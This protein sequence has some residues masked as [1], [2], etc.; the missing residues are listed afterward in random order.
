MSDISSSYERV[1]GGTVRQPW[2]R[3]LTCGRVRLGTRNHNASCTRQDPDRTRPTCHAAVFGL[4]IDEDGRAPHVAAD[5]RRRS[6][7]C[8]ERTARWDFPR[9]G[10][11]PERDQQFSGHRNDR[12]PACPALKLTDALTE[13]SGKFAFRLIT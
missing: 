2:L 8:S 11:A 12:D 7:C 10:K 13:P 4:T 5:C 1:W 3:N 6:L 9:L